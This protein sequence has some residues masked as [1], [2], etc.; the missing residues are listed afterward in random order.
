MG[1][2]GDRLAAGLTAF[3][4]KRASL[5][6]ADIIRQLD[7][8]LGDTVY[9]EKGGEIIP[10]VVGVDTTKRTPDMPPVTFITTCPEC[11]TPAPAPKAMMKCPKCGAESNGKFCPECG[12]PMAAVGPK[13]CPKCGTEVTGKFCPECGTPME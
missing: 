11:G 10:K 12:T 2:K 8:H 5:H 1:D 4:V 9:V 6:N 3:L 13:R 7:L